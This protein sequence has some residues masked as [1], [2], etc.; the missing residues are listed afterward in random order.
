MR[1]LVLLLA[2]TAALVFVGAAL[3]VETY[4]GPR[5]WNPGDSAASSWQSGWTEL[6]QQGGLGLRDDGDLHRQR[7]LF[8]ARDDPQPGHRHLYELV[9]VAGQESALHGQ[10]GLPLG[11]LPCVVGVS[12]S[13]PHR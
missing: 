7:F 1:K 4:G 2:L 8:L 13:H 9:V 12:S 11:W 10:H 5:Y 6:V 3:A